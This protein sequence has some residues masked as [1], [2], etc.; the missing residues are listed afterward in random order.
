[1]EWKE[2]QFHILEW[3]TFTGNITITVVTKVLYIAWDPAFEVMLCHSD[4]YQCLF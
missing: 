4:L 1:M 2:N 3:L